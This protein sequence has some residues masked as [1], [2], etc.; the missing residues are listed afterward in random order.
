MFARKLPVDAVWQN[1]ANLERIYV[2]IRC[3]VAG[4]ISFTSMRSF[5]P[6]NRDAL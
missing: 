4:F 1:H 3:Q 5:S 2:A 6:V